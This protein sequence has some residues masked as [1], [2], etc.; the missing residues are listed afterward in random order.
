MKE[1][2]K[3]PTQV[4]VQLNISVPWQFREDLIAIAKERNTSLAELVREAIKV[5][6]SDDLIKKHRKLTAEFG[7]TK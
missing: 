7:A 5:G 2:Q 3:D 6:L 1:R 4:P